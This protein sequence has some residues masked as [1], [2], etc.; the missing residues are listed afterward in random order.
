MQLKNVALTL[1]GAIGLGALLAFGIVKFYDNNTLPETATLA[2]VCF[3][4]G[5]PTVQFTDLKSVDLRDG[6]FSFVGADGLARALT[7]TCYAGPL[8]KPDPKAD[9]KPAEAPI[10]PVDQSVGQP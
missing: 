5:K 1:F 6:G 4:D 3:E 8:A 7:G 2:V 10:G 9:Q